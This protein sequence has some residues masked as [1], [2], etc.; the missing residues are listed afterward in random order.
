MIN[1]FACKYYTVQMNWE[2]RSFS[3]LTI[4]RP[5]NVAYCDSEYMDHRTGTF[6]VSVG[7]NILEIMHYN[8]SWKYT[9]LKNF[10]YF[11][12][13]NSII[14][15][16]V[17]PNYEWQQHIKKLI[18]NIFLNFWLHML[19]SYHFL[20]QCQYIRNDQIN[21]DMFHSCFIRILLRFS[22]IMKTSFQILWCSLWV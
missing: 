15:W 8:A 16:K 13:T 7:Y 5:E 4:S 10:H 17:W 9:F 18:F 19:L 3:F 20:L 6:F 2:K 12:N 1:T 21:D 14:K 11:I 22:Y